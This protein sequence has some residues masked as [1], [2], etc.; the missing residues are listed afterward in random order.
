M[1]CPS[2]FGR[3]RDSFVFVFYKCVS[4]ARTSTFVTGSLS[5]RQQQEETSSRRR[6]RR[7]RGRELP[8][9]H[10]GG[11]GGSSAGPKRHS[12]TSKATIRR[13]QLHAEMGSV[14]R[15][16]QGRLLRQLSARQMAAA[17]EQ[18]VLVPQAVFPRD[19]VRFR[20]T[21]LGPARTTTGRTR[22]D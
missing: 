14:H 3:H 2:T 12:S 19:L 16:T 13:R 4:C 9:N 17:Q 5:E 6:R 15:P 21:V 8:G 10:Q 1:A 22:C 20:Q 7:R 11:S 18:R